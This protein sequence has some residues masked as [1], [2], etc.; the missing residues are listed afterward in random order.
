MGQSFTLDIQKFVDKAK[1]NTKIV[2]Q[3]FAMTAFSR[4]I[5]R[6]PVDTGHLRSNWGCEVGNPYSQVTNTFDKG[7]SRTVENAQAIVNG[8]DG[9]GSI[10]LCNNLP[11]VVVLEYGRYP[12]PPKFGSRPK[13]LK[14]GANPNGF[15]EFRSAGGF[16]SQS[17]QGMVRVTVAEMGGVVEEIARSL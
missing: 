4:I 14:K 11:Y 6:T 8:W 15:M 1:G 13:G 16:S 3:K 12:N 5:Y 7:G 17:P 10:Y 2:C 9:K